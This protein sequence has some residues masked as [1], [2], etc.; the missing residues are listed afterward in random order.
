MYITHFIVS[1]QIHLTMPAV[2]VGVTLPVKQEY[3]YMMVIK[4]ETSRSQ[5]QIKYIMGGYRMRR[6][7]KYYRSLEP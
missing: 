5:R 4:K 1:I 7:S 2:A 3:T 6:V